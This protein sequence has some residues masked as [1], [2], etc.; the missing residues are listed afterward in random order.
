MTSHGTLVRQDL[1]ALL[2]RVR[3]G[4]VRYARRVSRSR[5]V[6]VLDYAGEE[7]AFLYSNAT[8][9]ILCFLPPGA[10]P[11]QEWAAGEWGP[12]PEGPR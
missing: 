10:T 2:A 7:V 8:R 12:L 5:T 4:Q 9:R 11:A 3:S 1:M 6:I